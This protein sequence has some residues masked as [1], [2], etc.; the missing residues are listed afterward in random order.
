[1]RATLLV[2]AALATGLL[3]AAC[4][5]SG[6]GQTESVGGGT[7]TVPAD[8]HG[9]YPELE[10]LLAQFP[11]QRWYTD[12][13]VARV[14]KELSPKEAE[15]LEELPE[16]TRAGKAEQIIA[17]AGPACEKSSK[18]AVIDPNASEKELALYRAGFVQPLRKVG[19]AQGF[20]GAQLECVEQTVE[21]LPG[22]KVVGLG[23]GTHQVRE[24][25]LLSVLA[26]CVKA[27]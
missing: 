25:I 9:V 8:V 27:Q 11:Y 26:Q 22:G 6:G 20:E 10:I 12:C 13:V 17:A 18:R 19:E 1:V 2:I 4:G 23:N 15:A 14:K 24:G 16:S 21:E 3:L 5:S 7:I